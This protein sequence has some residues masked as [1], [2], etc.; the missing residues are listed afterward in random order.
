M[1]RHVLRAIP[2]L[3]ILG[4]GMAAAD[5]PTLTRETAVH[6]AL[7]QNPEVVVARQEWEA[8][9]ARVT[10]ARALPDPVLELEYEELPGV[11]STGDFGERSFGATQTVEFPLKW[12]RRGQAVSQAAQAT[13][14]AVFEMA[15]LDVRSRV[16]TAFDRVLFEKKRLEYVLQ[17]VQLA[18]DFLKKARLR[19]EAGDV[20][21]LEVL[22][23]E[24]EAG[25]AAN[26]MTE[27]RNDLAV[28]KTKLN[29]LLSRPGQA[30]LELHGDLDYRPIDVELDRLQLL[31]LERR[32]DFLG[33]DWA[34]ESSLSAQA[35]A[36]AALLPDLDVGVFRQTIRGAVSDDD[37][38]RVGLSLEFPLWG[39]A[40]QRGELAE[41]KAVVGQAF[42]EKNSVR[43]QMSLEIESAFLAVQASGQQVELFQE[44]I[45]R[46]AERSFEVANRSYTEGKATYLEL[47]EAQQ[48]LVE[49]REEY[50]AALFN[51]RSALYQLER[52]SGGPLQ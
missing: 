31:A 34:V 51:Y 11:T 50:A 30:S 6:L 8:A 28:A 23:A 2:V 26:R 16:K 27:A 38:W 47:L 43:N 10:Q 42:A 18:Q 48:A 25:R 29:T 41:A 37:F 20:P 5:A 49:V 15:R 36:R 44:R 32:P 40:Q 13:R 14:Q 39:A 19:L 9:R 33:A 45:L 24:V 52:A 21:Q 7:D 46:E 17:N 3:C 4:L 12:W 1:Y 22:R 35:A